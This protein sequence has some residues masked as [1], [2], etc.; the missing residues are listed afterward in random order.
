MSDPTNW[1]FPDNLQ[2]KQSEV[3]FDLNAVFDAVVLV[4]AEIPDDAFTAEILGTE[5]IGN[6]IVINDD[7][8]VLTIGYLITEA[9]AVWLTTNNG[10]AVAAHPIA[11][12]QTTGFGLVMPLGKLAATPIERGSVR[13]ADVGD[14]VT[15]IGHG[16]RSHSLKASIAA[17]REFAGYW[18]YVLD[19]AIFTTPAHPQWGGSGCVDRDGKLLGIGSLFVQEAI[20]GKPSEGNMIVPIDLLEPIL[21]DM[22][23]LGR[24]AGLPR[25]WIGIY[26]QEA[27]G[28]LVVGGLASNGPAHKA[29]VRPGDVVIEVGGARVHKLPELF[30][31]I[32]RVGPAGTEIPMTLAR[33]GNVKR[34]Q[35]KSV[36][37]AA[38]MKKPQV[39]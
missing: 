8:L 6:G 39:H 30:R 35:I 19:E 31:K 20:D 38:L 17:K 5:R 12:D 18:E 23:T 24:P 25:P 21:D 34:V 1:S 28:H 4:R 9:H 10:A 11:Y 15:V 3:D 27:Q 32:W 29:G 7:G 2:P 13:T 22:L 36:D 16:G 33:D 14:A 26:V 37:R